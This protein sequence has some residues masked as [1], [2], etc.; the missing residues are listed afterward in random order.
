MDEKVQKARNFI[1]SKI[2]VVLSELLQ[3]IGSC[4]IRIV[5]DAPNGLLDLEDRLG[6]LRPFITE[7]EEAVR[8]NHPDDTTLFVAVRFLR[9]KHSYFV[10]DV[11]NTR[12][13][14]E[15]ADECRESIP[16]YV[17]RLSRRQP[18]IFRK[19]SLDEPLAE[20]LRE[21]HD[22]HGQSPLP[23]CDNIFDPHFCYANPRRLH[24]KM[25]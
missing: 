11:N 1:L 10:V 19:P 24:K 2:K 18:T 16:V 20:I 17:L 3:N 25:I 22:L 23:L 5:G 6:S 7:V 4:T 12:Y 8:Q 15:T 14:Y 21:L 9:G 13:N